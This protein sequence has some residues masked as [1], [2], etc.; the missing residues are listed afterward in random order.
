MDSV[1]VFLA[2]ATHTILAS[3]YLPR[4]PANS[5]HL[6]AKRVFSLVVRLIGLSCVFM[7]TLFAVTLHWTTPAFIGVLTGGCL[8]RY[9]INYLNSKAAGMAQDSLPPTVR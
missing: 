5:K 6:L 3:T 1:F 9:W 4:L 7:I 8:S 2:A